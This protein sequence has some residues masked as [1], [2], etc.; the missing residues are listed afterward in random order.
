[1][2]VCLHHNPVPVAAAWL[3]VHALKNPDELFAV[4]DADPRIR[5][6]LFGHIHHELN[7]ERN[8]VRYLGSPS[9]CVQFH[10]T[11]EDFALDALNPGYRWLDLHPD[12]TFH[13]GITRVT[14]KSYDVDFSGI[15]Y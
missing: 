6:V 1:V 13:T 10:P 11:S 3:Q 9:T 12:G 15:G 2:L 4:L 5:A 14:G 8:G 7:I